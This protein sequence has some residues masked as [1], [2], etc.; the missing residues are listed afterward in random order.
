MRAILMHEH[1]VFLQLVR[2][3]ETSQAMELHPPEKGWM[4]ESVEPTSGGFALLVWSEFC[5]KGRGL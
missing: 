1:K 3:P 4:L 2:W 5:P